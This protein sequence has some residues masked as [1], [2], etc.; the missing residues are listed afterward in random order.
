MVNYSK[1]IKLSRKNFKEEYE[2]KKKKMA[3]L[4]CAQ[5]FEMWLIW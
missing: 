2:K 1:V 5:D 4:V 3:V